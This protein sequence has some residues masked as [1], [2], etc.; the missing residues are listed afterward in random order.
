MQRI[1]VRETRFPLRLKIQYFLT[2]VDPPN[3]GNFTLSLGSRLRR[4]PEQD[5]EVGVDVL[6]AVQLR[7][8]AED[9]ALF[10]ILCGIAWHPIV[11]DGD[12]SLSSLLPQANVLAGIRLC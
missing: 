5:D 8:N 4:Y 10:L 11:Q 7:V 3:S 6:G 1:R 2:D 9:A 12:A